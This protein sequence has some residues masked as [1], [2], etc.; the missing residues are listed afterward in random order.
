MRRFRE[1]EA[2]SLQPENLDAWCN[3]GLFALIQRSMASAERSFHKSLAAL[4]KLQKQRGFVPAKTEPD[5]PHIS[6][7]DPEEDD[8]EENIC[9]SSF[10]PPNMPPTSHFP[11]HPAGKTAS[12]LVE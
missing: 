5:S 4:L 1:L 3:N 8:P 6:F 11:E 10:I 7:I 9:L 12:I 2:R